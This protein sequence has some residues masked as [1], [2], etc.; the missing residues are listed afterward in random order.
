MHADETARLEGRQMRCANGMHFFLN[1]K[2]CCLNSYHET[3]WI[4]VRQENDLTTDLIHVCYI[5]SQ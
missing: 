1:E 5:R 4:F 2:V 3:C